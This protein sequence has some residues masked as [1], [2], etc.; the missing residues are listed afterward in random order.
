[1]PS[2]LDELAQRVT[3]RFWCTARYS[4]AKALN[5]DSEFTEKKPLEEVQPIRGRFSAGRSRRDSC[6]S[7]VRRVGE[8]QEVRAKFPW[9]WEFDLPF[10]VR[11]SD[12]LKQ[13]RQGLEIL[14]RDA[15]FGTRPLTLSLRTGC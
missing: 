8:G 10:G 12:H 4:E 2:V 15:I 13:G 1:M 9:Y 7:F 6:L 11:P 3:L 14:W 5:L